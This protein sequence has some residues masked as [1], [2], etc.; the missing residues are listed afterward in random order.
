VCVVLGGA[1]RLWFALVAHPPLDHVYSDMRA[2]VA[3]ATNFASGAGLDRYD[4]F[5]PPGTSWLLSAPLWLFGAGRSG[6]WGAAV[7]WAL[8]SAATIF[9][10]WR[11]VATVASERAGVVTA[12]LVAVNP[13]FIINAGYFLSETPAIALLTAS[14]WLGY[15]AREHSGRGALARAVA[16]GLVGGAAVTV[17]PA[18]VLNLAVL[19]LPWLMLPALRRRLAALAAGAVVVIAV[20]VAYDSAAAGR[21]SGLGENAGIT[22]LQGQCDTDIVSGGRP[23]RP[24]VFRTPPAAQRGGSRNFD[25]PGH[26]IWDQSF[27]FDR[28]FDCIDDDGL[29]HLRIEARSLWEMTVPIVPWP[30]YDEHD[31]RPVAEAANDVYIAL[32]AG[33]LVV[34]LVLYR[35][36]TTVPGTRTLLLQLA[37]CI[38]VALIFFGDPRFR[39]PYDV[40]GIGLVALAALAL[41]D[42]RRRVPA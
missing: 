14:L 28:S 7:L 13:L 15:S 11:L 8:L 10:A 29:G 5:Q 32:L 19:A 30:A 16:A 42:R 3:V 1:L 40:F 17:R 38:P 36:G 22:F 25:F 39:M 24:Y 35:R 18:L 33:A 31:L 23:E 37:C 4:V 26:A 12:F 34:L 6:L 27:Y 2:Y 21:L 9:F 20:G 41:V